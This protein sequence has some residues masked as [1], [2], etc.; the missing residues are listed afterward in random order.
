L[1]LSQGAYKN[2]SLTIENDAADDVVLLNG[3][4]T[5]TCALGDTLC[6]RWNGTE[7][8]VKTDK[9]VGDFMQQLPSEKSPVEKCLEGAWINWS[10]RAVLYGISTAAPPSSVDYYSLVN[11]T[12]VANTTPV[13]CYHQAGGDYRLYKFKSSTAVYTVP[14]ELDLVK[15][16][17]LVPD[18]IDV[19]ES[20]QKLSQ[21]DLSTQE[22]TVTDDLHIGDIVADGVHAGKYV[23]E[24]IVPGGK[25][26]GVEGGNRPTFI[27]GGVQQDRIRNFS[28]TFISR[29]ASGQAGFTGPFQIGEIMANNSGGSSGNYK[30][31]FDPSLVVPTG[32]DNAPINLSVRYWRRVA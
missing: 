10:D 23:T 25:F 15:W 11:S 6:L 22:I 29:P 31:Y 19:R 16:D 7:W 21:K 18:V 26:F 20:C 14:A 9:H 2:V 30:I 17:Y 24:V 13:V 5:I 4:M 28:G 1:T 8:R 27:F 12:I 32:P 3:S